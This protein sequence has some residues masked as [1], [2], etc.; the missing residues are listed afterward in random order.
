MKI[1]LL[2]AFL[3][4]NL[5]LNAQEYIVTKISGGTA[6]IGTKL[7]KPET[8]LKSTDNITFSSNA[9]KLAMIE[10]AT[11]KNY[12]AQPKTDLTLTLKDALFLGK[13]TGTRGGFGTIYTIIDFENIFKGDTLL[14]LDNELKLVNKC[15]MFPMNENQFFY[16]EY[17]YNNERIPKKLNFSG[18]TL[19]IS[20]AELYKVDSKP[21]SDSLV[22]NYKLFYRNQ[23][24]KMSTEI[25]E[26]NPVFIETSEIKDE[27]SVLI[28]KFN[29]E[30]SEKIT[31]IQQITFYLNTN[32]GRPEKENLNNWLEKEFGVE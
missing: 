5:C 22:S 1:T 15:T 26:L 14:I 9:V 17:S 16:I 11:A 8:E 25:C 27:I 29:P 31:L 30:N 32:Y 13:S 20:K 7:I 24:T 23:T 2:I 3:S 6:K 18:D 12:F 10:S 28:K 4:I 21:I 19:I